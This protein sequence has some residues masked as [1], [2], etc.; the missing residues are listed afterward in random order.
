[1][2]NFKR[3]DSINM[4]D[5]MLG[6]GEFS[7]ENLAKS[8][9]SFGERLA[10]KFIGVI[11]DELRKQF[12]PKSN[13]GSTLDLINAMW[14]ERS[15]NRREAELVE[16]VKE[17]E[18]KSQQLA[19]DWED[20]CRNRDRLHGELGVCRQ[21][22]ETATREREEFRR[23]LTVENDHALRLK[24]ERNAALAREACLR[25]KLE[26]APAPIVAANSP[27]SPVSSASGWLTQDEQDAIEWCR[28][29]YVAQEIDFLKRNA[30]TH[31]WLQ[32][33]QQR[34][35]SLDSIIVK[36]GGKAKEQES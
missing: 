16:R 26:S 35:D 18:A 22:L 9:A 32:V 15:E 3:T 5:W 11:E 25:I 2:D 30:P 17:L 27:E 20:A 7:E 6:I 28:D 12:S 29:K 24:V 36:A 23:A 34:F 8:R 10:K 33:W 21:Q 13:D 14:K 31:P 1:M 4:R 19:S